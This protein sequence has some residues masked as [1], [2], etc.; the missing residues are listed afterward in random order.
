MIER[1]KCFENLDA[2]NKLLTNTRLEIQTK[3]VCIEIVWCG[4]Y[5]PAPDA[6]NMVFRAG[7]HKHSFHEIHLCLSGSY[8]YQV[9]DEQF[10]ITP[11][12]LILLKAEEYHCMLNKTDDFGKVALGFS[13]L[14]KKDDMSGELNNAF[15]RMPA[16]VSRQTEEI[17]E[18]F[19]TVLQEISQQKIGYLAA[20]NALLLR[21]ILLC[22]RLNEG[23]ASRRPD[24]TSRVDQRVSEL[25]TY[26]NSRIH[27]PISCQ[28]ISDNIHLSARQVNRIIQNE[29]GMSLSA[30]IDRMKCAHA[31]ELLLYSDMPTSKIAASIGYSNEFSFSKFFKR[32]EGMPPSQFRRSRF[33]G[34]MKV[35]LEDEWA[36]G[37]G[38][39]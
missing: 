37:A 21:V 16:L 24:F 23:S 39:V 25:N 27:L 18:V 36:K 30:Y 22:A 6:S 35:M 5:V 26:I 2:V 19:Y 20:V 15:S 10:T 34:Y 3:E 8:V 4:Y 31:K 28:E 1:I 38:N 17:A 14:P 33:G 9:G 11:G 12:D 13:I 7:V 32:V 29:F